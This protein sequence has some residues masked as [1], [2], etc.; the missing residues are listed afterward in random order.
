[1][2]FKRF[3][4]IAK[5]DKFSVLPELPTCM[6][7]LYFKNGSRNKHDI[8]QV[9]SKFSVEDGDINILKIGEIIVLL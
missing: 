4:K 3:L 1:M 2:I 5:F 8:W 9:C 7:V 6:L